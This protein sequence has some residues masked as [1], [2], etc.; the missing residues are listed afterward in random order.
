MSKQFIAGRYHI[1]KQLGEGAFGKTYLA[2]DTHMPENKH[3]VA[4]QLKPQSTDEFTI[5]TAK[6]LFPREAAILNK[7]GDQHSQ[8]PRLLAH[9]EEDNEFY[10]V[11][12]YI[13]GCDL[14]EEIKPGIKLEE[15]QVVKILDEILEVLTFVHQESVI[16]RDIK[17]SNIMR[18]NKDGK[19]FLIDFGAVKEITTRVS[20]VQY[21]TII[22]GTDGYMPTEQ[23]RGQTRYASDIY[24][25]GMMAIFALTGIA[26]NQLSYDRDTGE[27]EWRDD[28]SVNPNLAD[29]IDRMVRR[30]YRD[31]YRSATEAYQALQDFINPAIASSSTGSTERILS[32]SFRTSLFSSAKPKSSL[33]KKLLIT[34]VLLFT[35]GGGSYYFL[36]Q[37]KTSL[38]LTYD[39]SEYDID[40]NYPENW[41][42]EKVD[43]SF[44]TLARFY[45]PKNDGENVLVTLEAIEINQ[46]ISL[47]DYSNSAI[48]KIV[49]YLPGAK[50]IDS[51]RIEL[52]NKPAHRIVYTGKK[53]DSDITNKYLQ[54][55]FQESDRIFTMT[56][57]APEAK[58]PDFSETVEQTMIPSLVKREVKN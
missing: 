22:I 16:H 11:Q 4:K 29:I 27:C 13:E 52:S 38:F 45:P 40:V 32:T 44:G 34:T 19:L 53:K 10:L 50:I 24:A 2:E 31:R 33:G 49:Q 55:W 12:E 18:R 25:L 48:N 15:S 9:L 30:D 14:G 54:V 46:S 43:D 21:S 39:N 56:Y 35:L 58:Y 47:D 28:I 20:K 1:L 17:P 7:L 42:L 57:V 37:P 6:K 23:A 3:C 41:V 51:R 26:P 5:N 8:I 36:Q